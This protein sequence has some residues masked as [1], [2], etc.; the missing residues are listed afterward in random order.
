MA[1]YPGDTATINATVKDKKGAKIDATSH[2]IKV[3]DPDGNLKGTYTDPARDDIGEYHL[4]YAIPSDGKAGTWKAIWK[5]VTAEGTKTESITF[6][7]LI[8]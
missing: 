1:L 2:S 6:D 4:N 3:Y 8:A 5:A 7:V